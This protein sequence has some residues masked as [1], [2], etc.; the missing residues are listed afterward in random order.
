MTF[1]M[2]QPVGGIR[3][4]HFSFIIFFVHSMSFVFAGSMTR[5]ADMEDSGDK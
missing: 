3:T 4:M 1:S 5:T 2:K